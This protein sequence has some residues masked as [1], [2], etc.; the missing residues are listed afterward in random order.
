MYVRD[1]YAVQLVEALGILIP[2]NYS[3]R[4]IYV[5]IEKLSKFHNA[6]AH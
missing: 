2:F 1:N 5:P 3:L 4:K 6:Y